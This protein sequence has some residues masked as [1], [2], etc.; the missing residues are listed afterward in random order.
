[1]GNKKMSIGRLATLIGTLFAYLIGA[2][3][4][5][6]Q[7]TV[8]F[9]ASWGSVWATLLVGVITFFMMYLAYSAYAYVGRTRSI[10]DVSG[11]FEFYSGPIFG[12]L[13]EAF[14]WIFNG[15]A[16]VFMVSCFGNVMLQQWGFLLLL[17]MLSVSVFLWLQLRLG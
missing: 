13:F 11:I 10:D 1:M 15:C 7:E 14:A 5:S 9:F 17:E 2:G 16:Y 3:F 12:R 6:G 8:Q 4:A